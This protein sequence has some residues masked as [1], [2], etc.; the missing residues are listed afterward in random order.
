MPNDPCTPSISTK[1]ALRSRSSS[2]TV[3]GTSATTMFGPNPFVASE[4]GACGSCE[5]IARC[6][7]RHELPDVERERQRRILDR[8][9]ARQHLFRNRDDLIEIRIRPSITASSTS[10]G[11][12][13]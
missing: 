2:F 10:R 1:A 5:R 3:R 6:E 9:A 12:S 8:A 4:G 7:L 13:E 11:A